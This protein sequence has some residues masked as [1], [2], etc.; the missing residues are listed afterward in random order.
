M[1]NIDLE[2]PYEYVASC[3]PHLKLCVT[4]MGFDLF[5]YSLEHPQSYLTDNMLRLA[6]GFSKIFTN[7]HMFN[8]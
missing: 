1:G 2:H 6:L 5:W 7:G 3:S 4:R 8:C